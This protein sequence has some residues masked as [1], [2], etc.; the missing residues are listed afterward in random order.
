[1]AVKFIKNDFVSMD[2][3]ADNFIESKKS[4]FIGAI[5]EYETPNGDRAVGFMNRRAFLLVNEDGE[6]YSREDLLAA[7]RDSA[8]EGLDISDYYEDDFVEIANTSE[9]NEEIMDYYGFDE[10][11][12]K[13]IQD[14][15]QDLSCYWVY[16]ESEEME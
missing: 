6:V 5:C 14:R 12:C 10:E 11:D 4:G 15:L 13:D 3:I 7:I 9:I 8:K 2:W 1:M 16:V